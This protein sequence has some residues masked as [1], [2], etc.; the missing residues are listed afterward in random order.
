MQKTFEND[1]QERLII[2]E[3]GLLIANKEGLS[4]IPRTQIGEGLRC[5]RGSLRIRS[6]QR[7][8]RFAYRRRNR[9]EL[10]RAIGGAM[11]AFILRALVNGCLIDGMLSFIRSMPQR[12][13]P[14]L[15]RVGGFFPRVCPAEAGIG[16]I[17]F[18][19]N[20]DFLLLL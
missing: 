19:E 14:S 1:F 12:F 6:G 15:R 9:G 17:K 4:L 7:L 11:L 8:V 20:V 2:A 10:L 16:P 18:K 5:S 3:E 13:L